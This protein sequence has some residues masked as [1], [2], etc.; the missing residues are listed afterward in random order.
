LESTPI[1]KLLWYLMKL[2]G[3]NVEGHG[4]K[5]PAQ[6]IMTTLSKIPYDTTKKFW[7]KEEDPITRQ[8]ELIVQ[9]N[10]WMKAIGMKFQF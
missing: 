1:L 7:A 8:E 9:I 3:A 4:K 6:N 2:D 5:K 10:L